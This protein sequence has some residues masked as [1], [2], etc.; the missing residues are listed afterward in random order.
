MR[1]ISLS[2]FDKRPSRLAALPLAL[3]FLLETW[4]WRKLVAFARFVST[5]I[6]WE[7][8]RDA[9]RRALARMPAIVSVALFA[10]PLFVSEFGSFLS[11]VMMATGHLFAGMALYVLM[12]GLGLVLVPVIFEITRER[13][14][15]L[16]WFAWGYAK[17]EALHMMAN[18]FVAPYRNAAAQWARAG[19]RALLARVYAPSR[20]AARARAAKAETL[21]SSAR[22]VGARPA[23]P[24]H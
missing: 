1:A 3:L 21:A 20:S 12:K 6:P 11:V 14:L 19:W 9:A 16:P 13:L 10:I 7:R 4:I 22:A 2:D 24:S 8:F 23:S 17:F 18:R 15:G 5:L